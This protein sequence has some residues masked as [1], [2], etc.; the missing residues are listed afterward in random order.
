VF[1]LEQT[2]RK[3]KWNNSGA[4]QK[5]GI[6]KWHKGGPE[7]HLDPL[8]TINTSTSTLTGINN[9]LTSN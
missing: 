5:I 1:S 6:T 4:K 8:I 2:C 9:Q 3:M 7:G